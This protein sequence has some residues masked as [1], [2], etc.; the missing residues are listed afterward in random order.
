MRIDHRM[1]LPEAQSLLRSN[2]RRS[3]RPKQGAFLLTCCGRTSKVTVTSREHSP[4]RSA[5]MDLALLATLKDKLATATN[6]S[7]V[8]V[9]FFDHFGEEAEFMAL[10][11]TGR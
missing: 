9:Y 6:F 8:M 10:G 4:L 3:H 11:E 1:A 2:Y 5:V 7:E